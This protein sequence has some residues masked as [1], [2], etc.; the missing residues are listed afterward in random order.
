MDNIVPAGNTGNGCRTKQTAE[1]ETFRVWLGNTKMILT[2]SNFR[3]G[4]VG[5]ILELLEDKNT[6][7]VMANPDGTF[8]IEMNNFPARMLGKIDEKRIRSIISTIGSFTNKRAVDNLSPCLET[9]LPKELG[10]HRISAQVPPTCKPM[11]TIRRRAETIFSL[12]H[13]LATGVIT[14]KQFNVI[15]DAIKQKN[16]IIVAG[17]T[18]SG[19]TT[20]ANAVLKKMDEILPDERIVI[21]EDTEELQCTSRNQVHWLTSQ[22]ASYKDLLIQTLRVRPD[23]I[24]VGETRSGEA[25]Q[26]FNGWLSHRG[27]VSTVHADNISKSIER[28]E[29]MTREADGNNQPRKKLIGE[30]VDLIVS[31]IRKKAT[32]TEP[33][34][35]IVAE[36]AKLEDYLPK[37]DEYIF[38]YRL[39]HPLYEEFTQNEFH[40]RHD[41]SD[42]PNKMYLNENELRKIREEIV[43]R[44]N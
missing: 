32:E 36:L 3:E 15:V 12:E 20:F 2:Q 7:D 23:R 25:V 13:Y 38:S 39:K 40:L 27:G 17:V 35:R 5:D 1:E 44:H 9:A 37:D 22:L 33:S 34:R 24:I 43:T 42:E 11:F 28:L 14:G 21:I 30:N 31:L 41:Y 26:L 4:Y 29:Q 8:W 19:K 6:T 10:C 18:G 16:N